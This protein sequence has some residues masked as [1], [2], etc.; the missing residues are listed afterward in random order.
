MSNRILERLAAKSASAGLTARSD[1]YISDVQRIDHSKCRV[2]VGYSK[3]V[4]SVPTLA[5]V[6]QYFQHTFGNKVVAQLS[7][8]Q[9]HEAESAISLMVTLNTPTRPMSDLNDMIR[10]S[11][12]SYMDENTKHLWHVV[13]TG[14]VKYLARQTEENVAEIVEARRART[15]KKEA[16]FETLKTAAPIVNAGD[17]VKFMSPQNVIMMGEVS[18]ISDAKATIRANG[19][20]FSVDRQAILQV[21]ER[22]SKSI[23]SEKNI[24]EDYFAKAYGDASFA[25]QLTSK[26]PQ[27]VHGLGATVPSA[28]G[29]KAPSRNDK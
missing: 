23:Q 2:L 3:Q 6:E 9:A 21:V 22:A 25:K 27:D 28:P 18:S 13:D 16:R 14:S 19:G 1:M 26:V 4:G 17:T 10:V 7:S 12:N 24:L 5:Q 11:T 20:S 15:S 8:A 29:A